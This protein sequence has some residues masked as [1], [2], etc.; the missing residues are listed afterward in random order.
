MA[1]IK[2]ES[3]VPQRVAWKAVS[4]GLSIFLLCIFA[5]AIVSLMLPGEY[6]LD[7]GALIFWILVAVLLAALIGAIREYRLVRV[8]YDDVAELLIEHAENPLHS[9]EIERLIAERYG[10]PIDGWRR[11]ARQDI[12]RILDEFAQ[13]GILEKDFCDGKVIMYQLVVPELTACTTPDE[14]SRAL[15]QGNADFPAYF[16]ILRYAQ[17][18]AER[19]RIDGKTEGAF[20]VSDEMLKAHTAFS[21]YFRMHE[22]DS[23]F[24][25]TQR[26][27]AQI[28]NA[29]GIRLTGI[30]RA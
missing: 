19:I 20:I 26:H 14:L 2:Q 15:R 7:K 29:Y 1:T 16:G 24:D 30:K 28:F 21:A 18:A 25:V 17:D 3:G 5:F 6:R 10:L 8:L 9:S 12:A 22:L 23:A 4:S 13:I 27:V 11:V